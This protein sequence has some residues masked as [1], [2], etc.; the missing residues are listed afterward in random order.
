MCATYFLTVSY[1]TGHWMV[2]CTICGAAASPLCTK[3][4]GLQ[5]LCWDFINMLT[6]NNN[7]QKKRI[8][9]LTI[10]SDIKKKMFSFSSVS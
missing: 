4:D 10:G 1:G 8:L 6:I 7:D 2:V 3:N 9:C 5:S